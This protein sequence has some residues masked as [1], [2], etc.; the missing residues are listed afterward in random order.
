M[1]ITR[2]QVKKINDKMANGWELDL[3]YLFMRGEKTASLKIHQD[4][5]GYIEGKLY[6]DNVSDWHPGAYNGIQIK[7]C[8]SRWYKGSTEGVFVSHGMGKWMR[9]N[10]P[11]LKR[12]M[13]SEVQ[14]I[15]HRITAADIMSIYQD[16][17]AQV[18][19]D[20]LVGASA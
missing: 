7:L 1:K 15:T 17:A 2:E 4:D 13:F 8:V 12:C 5:G 18:N 20:L 6:I 3:Y 11:D 14:K 9:I 16:N 19:S 10:R